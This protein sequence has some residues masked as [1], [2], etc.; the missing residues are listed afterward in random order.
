MQDGTGRGAGR[1]RRGFAGK[2]IRIEKNE[3]DES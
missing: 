2:A 1:C 3:E